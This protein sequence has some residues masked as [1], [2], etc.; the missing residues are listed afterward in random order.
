MATVKAF[1]RVSKKKIKTA[2]IRFRL[3]DGRKVQLFHQSD[4]TIDPN[5]WD[6]SKEAVK[7]KVIFENRDWMRRLN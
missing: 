5:L 3:S 2:N 1:I 7:A 6:E 4:I